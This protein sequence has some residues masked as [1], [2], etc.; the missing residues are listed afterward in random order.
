MKN[1]KI[2]LGIIWIDEE[3]QTVDRDTM[4]PCTQ[5]P[6][7]SYDH[8]GSARFVLEISAEEMSELTLS[9]GDEWDIIDI[10]E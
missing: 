4:Q 1:T 8:Q 3:L 5:D 10:Q 6:C 2:P 7:P 9:R